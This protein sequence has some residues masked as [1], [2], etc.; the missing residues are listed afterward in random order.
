[1][2]FSWPFERH[3]RW[4]KQLDAYVDGELRADE[5]AAFEAHLR[6]CARCE[7]EVLARRELKQMAA[8]L[9][10]LPAPRSFQVTPGM[11][12]EA[13]KERAHRGTPVVMRLAQMTAGLAAV[14]FAG[15][16]AAHITQGDETGSEQR[17]VSEDAV[18]PMAESQGDDDGAGAPSG[19]IGTATVQVQSTSS[20][21]LPEV[22][23]PAVGG[24]GVRPSE[25]PQTNRDSGSES[26][27]TVVPGYS[28]PLS[29]SEPPPADEGVTSSVG[30]DEDDDDGG[31]SG[32]VL[33]EVGLAALAGVATATW[34]VARRR[35]S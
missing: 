14:A 10:Q 31:V 16:V 32:F 4:H 28:N 8:T 29:E 24:A 18:N 13:P 25:T 9:P 19:P 5:L 12:V 11:L 23:T 20:T 6:S 27:A 2:G 26:V 7:P 34:L 17:A 30:P 1:M 21:E 33:A 22:E 15:V 3:R 35:A